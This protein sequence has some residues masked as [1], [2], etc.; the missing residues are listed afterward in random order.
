MRK[1]MIA[2]L[3]ILTILIPTLAIVGVSHFAI[4]PVYATGTA[5][6]I[7]QMLQ[8][9][10]VASGN[11]IFVILPDYTVTLTP[12]HTP[13]SK[14][15]SRSAA[16]VTDTYAATYL[17]GAFVKD[18]N[19]IL[20]TNSAY[21]SQAAS[22][23]CG[24]PTGI[25]STV[26]LVVMAG[27]GVSETSY[28]YQ[29]ESAQS[30]LYANAATLCIVRRDT[31][32]NIICNPSVSET[33][34]YFVMESFLDSSNRPV[35]LLW[36]W[37]WRGTFA[38]AEYFADFVIRNSASY[39]KSWYVYRW[40]EGSGTSLNSF[41][42]SGDTFTQIA[43]GPSSAS[44]NKALV[45]NAVNLGRQALLR[46][47]KGDNALA[48]GMSAES[49]YVGFPLSLY[50]SYYGATIKAGT[51]VVSITVNSVTAT[52]EDFEYNFWNIPD[53]NAIQI[54]IGVHLD[55]SPKQIRAVFRNDFHAFSTPSSI[56][57]YGTLISSSFSSSNV[58]ASVTKF[59]NPRTS[60]SALFQSFR[61]TLRHGSQ[62]G[63][64]LYH[65]MGD[66]TKWS[67]LQTGLSAYGFTFDIYDPAFDPGSWSSPGIDS[68][69]TFQ[70]YHDCDVNSQLPVTDTSYPYL[71]KVCTLGR[72]VYITLSAWD[73]LV[74]T[75]Q[76]LFVLRQYGPD[77]HY[78]AL[79]SPASGVP[80]YWVDRTP[81]GWARTME[82][83]WNGYGIPKPGSTQYGTSVRTAAFGILETYLGYRWG[84]ATSKGWADMVRDVFLQ[85]QVNAVG[86]Y[87]S[88]DLNAVAFRPLFA[89]MWFT[90]WDPYKQAS[91]KGIVDQVSDLFGMSHEYD[92]LIPGNMETVEIVQQFFNVYL[93]LAFP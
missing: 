83:V 53:L 72:T 74:P 63:W 81:R 58:G 19:E 23:N 5:I 25:G 40:N 22:P 64:K 48:S 61:Y 44:V 89:G 7:N 52:S 28:Y 6:P 35:Y 42:D 32:A 12:G 92:G 27:L 68:F 13:A 36:G 33:Q 55:F 2:Q 45:Q 88:G 10:V 3:L 90:A 26:P 15:A 18:Q 54:K 80:A 9:V 11:T 14:C 73:N 65:D 29:I 86:Y 47:Y 21:I 62:M 59:Y 60:D 38:S 82:S 4:P 34:D 76:A 37:A 31:G 78:Q 20:D 85:T 43:V 8:N 93:A 91:P 56:Y 84:D 69:Y 41:P 71:S 57:L 16:M 50:N 87:K 30:Q 66:Q 77:Y 70:A 67:Q 79:Y 24:N 51:P 39:T 17:F 49:E 46:L 1:I 75:L